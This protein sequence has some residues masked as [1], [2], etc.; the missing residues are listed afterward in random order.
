MMSADHDLKESNYTPKIKAKRNQGW[1][2]RSNHIVEGMEVTVWVHLLA[3]V[4]ASCMQKQVL[5]IPVSNS[6]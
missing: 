5:F 3:G 2:K 4:K 1:D 6:L